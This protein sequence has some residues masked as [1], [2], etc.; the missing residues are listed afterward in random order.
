METTTRTFENY[1]RVYREDW[2]WRY[3]GVRTHL[4][5]WYKLRRHVV[6][7]VGLRPGAPVLEIAC[8]QGYHVDVMRRMGFDVTGI[9]LSVGGI[10]FARRIFPESRY[11]HLDATGPLPFDSGSFDL[12]WS[13]GAGFFHYDIHTPQVHELIGEHVRLVRPGGHYLIMISSDLSGDHP[14]TAMQK[15]WQHTLEDLRKALRPQGD[16]IETDWFPIRRWLVGPATK[17]GYAVATL[18]VAPST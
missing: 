10:D 9:D 1:D 13:H 2:H 3:T 17:N 16:D 18:R 5:E 8:G 4:R 14:D 11:L 15:E 12:V 7:R 6:R